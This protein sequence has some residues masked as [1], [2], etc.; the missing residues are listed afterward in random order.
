MLTNNLLT[1]YFAS[2]NHFLNKTSS[3]L[4]KNSSFLT[5][6]LNELV[7]DHF[8]TIKVILKNPQYPLLLVHNVYYYMR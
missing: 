2:F 3:I 1:L 4:S 6:K 8:T 7:V 5:S